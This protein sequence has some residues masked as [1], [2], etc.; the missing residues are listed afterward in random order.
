MKKTGKVIFCIL[1]AVI[2]LYLMIWDYPQYRAKLSTAAVGTDHKLF[3]DG[4]TG[5]N[6]GG[7]K[8]QEEKL[9]NQIKEL[10]EQIKKLEKQQKDAGTK[11]YLYFDQVFESCYDQLYPQMKE[12]GYTGTMVLTDGQLP[13]DYLQMT[14]TQCTEMLDNGWELAVGGSKQ[15]DLTA[16]LSDVENEWRAYLE[17]YLAEIKLR[18]NVVPTVYCFNEGE[19]RKEFDDILRDYGFKTIRYYGEEDLQQEDGL[20]RIRAYQVAQDTDNNEAVNDLKN[21]S[22][23][24]L[25]TRRVAA[26]V[27][28]G[29]ENIQIT[30]YSELLKS[31]TETDGLNI[32]GNAQSNGNQAETLERQIEDLKNQRDELIQQMNVTLD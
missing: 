1:S 22:A 9:E 6:S 21:Y 15:I 19:Y 16:D 30:K 5:N 8:N 7:R 27:Q 32:I 18:L 24:A 31:I 2:F 25:C 11:V 26:E 4:E 13:G 17:K 23:V 20:T 12:M 29:A 10:D 14:E 28:S 3:S